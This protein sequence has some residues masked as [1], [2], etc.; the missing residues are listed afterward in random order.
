MYISIYIYIYMI[1]TCVNP[2]HPNLTRAHEK[3][4]Q[5]LVYGICI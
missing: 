5:A 3:T 4:I 1:Y 2:I